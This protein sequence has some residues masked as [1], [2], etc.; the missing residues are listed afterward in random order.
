MV[1][2]YAPVASVPN[3]QVALPTRAWVEAKTGP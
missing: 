3:V 1:A 2:A